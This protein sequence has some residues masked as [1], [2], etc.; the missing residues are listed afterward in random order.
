MNDI[1]FAGKHVLTYNVSRHK[2]KTWELIYCTGD[3]GRLIFSDREMPYAEGDI[4]VIPPDMPHENVSS[5]GFTNIHLNVEN[6][7]LAYRQPTIVHDDG[8]HSLLHLFAD[9]YYLFCGNP[10]RRA[11]LLSSYGNL[12]VRHISLSQATRPRNRIVEEIE[13]SIVQNYANPNYE[14]DEVLS[15]MPYCYDYLCRLFRQEVCTTPHK[16]LTNLRL[17]VAADML[18]SGYAEGGIAE[19][20]HMCGFRDPLYFSRLFKKR[21]QASP[22]AYSRQKAQPAPEDPD[23]QKI[24]D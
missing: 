16:Y 2:H 3:S 24:M 11:A 12:I 14:L 5:E 4:V 19:I 17:Q 13:Q 15:A 18:L 10:E 9:A 6:A 22:S 1:V 7:T 8:N 21:Y 23:S 20:A